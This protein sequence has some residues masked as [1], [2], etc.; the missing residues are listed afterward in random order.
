MKGSLQWLNGLQTVYLFESFHVFGED[1]SIMPRYT[2]RLIAAVRSNELDALLVRWMEVWNRFTYERVKD[3]TWPR[4]QRIKTF[5]EA[6][7]NFQVIKEDQALAVCLEDEALNRTL[8]LCSVYSDEAGY[9]KI[10]G[11][12]ETHPESAQVNLYTGLTLKPDSLSDDKMLEFLCNY[13]LRTASVGPEHN[14]FIAGSRSYYF[15]GPRLVQLE[16]LQISPIACRYNSIKKVVAVLYEDGRE[17]G[18]S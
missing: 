4:S 1:T 6:Q 13:I 17:M 10:L 5:L 12:G 9:T 8:L 18:S 11:P 7:M 15:N 16:P 14:C 2:E 3:S